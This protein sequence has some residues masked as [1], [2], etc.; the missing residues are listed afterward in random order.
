MLRHSYA[1]HLH[2][3]GMDIRNIQR[4][5]G[6]NCTKTTEIY[7]YVSKRDI[8]QLKSPLDDLDV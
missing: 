7:T 8:S 5:L 4:L 2:D 6:H 1:T 3:A